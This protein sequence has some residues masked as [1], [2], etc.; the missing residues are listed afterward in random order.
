MV[1]FTGTPH[2]HQSTPAVEWAVAVLRTDHR[3]GI[4]GRSVSVQPPLYRCHLCLGVEAAVTSQMFHLYACTFPSPCIHCVFIGGTSLSVQPSLSRCHLHLEDDGSSDVPNIP[5]L[6]LQVL[7]PSP[8]ID[9]IISFCLSNAAAEARVSE[10]EGGGETEPRSS[11]R[12]TSK[13]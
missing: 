5:P 2:A 7:L 9:F 8:S 13:V 4:N 1:C 12:R 10:W 6:C 11:V 3:V